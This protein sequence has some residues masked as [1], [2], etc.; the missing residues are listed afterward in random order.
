MKKMEVNKFSFIV[1]VLF[2]YPILP[3]YVYIVGGVNV[4]NGLLAISILL[5]MVLYGKLTKIQ[6][7]N[8]II[9][10]W[11]FLII[12]ALSYY[13]DAGIVK[14]ATYVM[15]FILLPWILITVINSEKRFYKAIDTLIFAGAFIGV[16]GIIEAV[17]KFNFIQ[18]LASGDIEFFHEIRY[19]LLRIMTTFGQ[20]I[21]YGLYQVF[22]IALIN[23]RKGTS[24]CGRMLNICYV[25]SALNI[26]LS[27]SRIPIIAFILIQVLMTYRESKKKFIN[28]LVAFAIGLM[29]YLII[30]TSL[31]FKIPFIDDILETFNQLL[32][33]NTQSSGSTVGFGNRFDLWTW[34]YLSMGNKWMT[35]HGPTA[36]FAYKVYEW[37]TKKSIENQYL[38]ILWHN[39]LIGLVSMLL[40]YVSILVYSFK[41]RNRTLACAEE[42][43]SFNTMIFFM[44]LVYYVVEFG[45]QES[46]ISRIYTVFVALLIAY[47]RIE[48]KGKQK[49]IAY[50]I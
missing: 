20:P 14:T 16:L 50:K 48:S 10:Y 5:Y 27:V 34:V 1:A 49:N 39:G 13:I 40:S 28:W 4:V 18:P 33:G 23:Y 22:I 36:E 37:Q 11:L 42:S 3:Q 46:D 24:N 45:V 26:F 12:M 38:N 31:G 17:L 21:A 2:L 7:R 25:I 30:L 15:S 9:L 44:M 29:F 41:R 6:L 35:G 19:G 32:S 8:D 47:N 43:M